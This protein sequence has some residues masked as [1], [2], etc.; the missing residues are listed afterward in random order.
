[1]KSIISKKLITLLVLLISPYAFT[2][3]MQYTLELPPEKFVIPAFSEVYSD[4]ESSISPN[5]YEL[6]ENLK[7]LLS[8]KNYMEVKLKLDEFYDIELSP[9]LLLLKAQ[10][11]FS[12]KEYDQAEKIYM[13]VLKRKPQ[14]VRAHEDMGQ[15]Y[16]IRNNLEKAQY[17]FSK[18]IS[19]GSESALIHGQLGYINLQLNGAFSAL[20]A[21]QKAL[22]LEP[23]NKHWQQ[24]LL[25]SLV[26]SKMYPSA[27]ALLTELIARNPKKQSY[28]LTKAAIELDNEN[29]DSALQ[30]I[31]YALLLGPISQ[32]NTQIA[33]RLHLQ[34][35]SYSRAMDII[36]NINKNDITIDNIKHYLFWLNKANRFE[37]SE[38]L[39]ASSINSDNITQADQSVLLTYQADIHVANNNK[40]KAINA[41]EKAIELNENNNIA[42]LKYAQYL[43]KNKE[44]YRTE[45]LFIRAQAF[46]ETHL[47]ALLGRAQLYIN[48]EDM[49]SAYSLLIDIDNKYPN[50]H[51]IKAQIDTLESIVKIEKSLMNREKL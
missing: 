47:N 9:A 28:W 37:D 48:T 44:Y 3:G 19:Y 20:F 7:S 33:V 31:E 50:T 27:M 29:F 43:L 36:N 1:M 2:K 42:L 8:N 10:L 25:T 26:S 4:R 40:P 14:F 12:I 34:Q 24:G 6:A 17:H 35:Q 39:I 32:Q 49:Q 13:R 18:A 30:S 16:L 21:Y 22:S 51:G 38:S 41:F 46:E 23:N 5:E 45:A 15:L 11:Y